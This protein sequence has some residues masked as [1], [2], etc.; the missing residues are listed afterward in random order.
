MEWSL[1]HV[2][3][4]RRKKN[5]SH[6]WKF[7]QTDVLMVHKKWTL[8]TPSE[9]MRISKGLKIYRSCRLTKKREVTSFT[10]VNGAYLYGIRL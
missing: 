9:K 3:P 4:D 1:G 7:H 8:G 2:C 6:K 5:Q 10:R